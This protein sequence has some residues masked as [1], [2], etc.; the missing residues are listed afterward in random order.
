MG[1]EKK[2]NG[3]NEVYYTSCALSFA[4]YYVRHL[5]VVYKKK[6]NMG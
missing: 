6:S 5:G 1:E 3:T 4:W 2:Q